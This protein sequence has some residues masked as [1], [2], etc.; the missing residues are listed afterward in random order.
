LIVRR[1]PKRGEV[2]DI[3]AFDTQRFPAGRKQMQCWHTA[4]QLFRESGSSVDQMFAT[5]EDKQR[6]S[7]QQMIDQGRHN[8]VGL[9][10]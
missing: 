7:F 5:V 6:R 2:V 8:I 10:R 1:T 3:L 9:Y 4:K